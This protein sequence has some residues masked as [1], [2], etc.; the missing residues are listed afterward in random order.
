MDYFD[1]D[2]LYNMIR[3]YGV[4]DTVAGLIEMLREA[5]DDLSDEG[6]KEQAIQAANMADALQELNGKQYGEYSI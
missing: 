3:N 4:K 1:K 5:A 6:L 2:T